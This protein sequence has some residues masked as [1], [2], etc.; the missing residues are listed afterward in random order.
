MVLVVVKHFFHLIL[1]HLNLLAGAFDHNFMNWFGWVRNIVCLGLLNRLR[2]LNVWLLRHDSF[3]FLSSVVKSENSSHAMV[4]V[5][6]ISLIPSCVSNTSFL[7]WAIDIIRETIL[8]LVQITSDTLSLHE[9]QSAIYTHLIVS[10][11]LKVLVG[12]I[13][14]A[15]QMRKS[16][17]LV[18]SIIWINLER[19][20]SLEFFN[21]RFYSTLAGSNLSYFFLRWS[22]FLDCNLCLYFFE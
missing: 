22:N 13:E 21:C 14:N 15:G 3:E 10:F 5:V 11:N 18:V 2:L 4:C 6:H 8:L 17:F 7:T 9:S 16:P 20:P 1:C 19:P 12:I